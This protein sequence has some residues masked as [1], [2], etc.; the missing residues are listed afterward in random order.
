MKR[1]IGRVYTVT[2]VGRKPKVYSGNEA[3]GS[4]HGRRAADTC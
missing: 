4:P 1:L 3:R 2:E